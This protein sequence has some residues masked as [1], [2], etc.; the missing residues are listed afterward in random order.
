LFEE[1]RSKRQDDIDDEDSDITPLLRSDRHPKI[2]RMA[3][4]SWNRVS[5]IFNP[6]LLAAVVALLVGI[7][8][9]LKYL[10]FNED[11]ALYS[12]LTA[13]ISQ[14]G[15]ACIPMVMITLGAELYTLPRNNSASTKEMVTAIIILKMAIMPVIGGSAVLLLRPWIP[16][17]PM[18]WFVLILLAASPT[19]KGVNIVVT[20]AALLAHIAICFLSH[21]LDDNITDDS[22]L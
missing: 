9:S 22:T 12:S 8:P 13:T 19:G 16:D 1:G 17:D 2:S 7:I 15:S 5:E 6:P 18:L 21:Q 11:G 3:V 14:L 10:F 4:K 20:N